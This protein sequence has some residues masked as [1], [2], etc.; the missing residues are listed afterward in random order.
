MQFRHS[1]KHSWDTSRVFYMNTEKVTGLDSRRAKHSYLLVRW[2]RATVFLVPW[3]IR[4]SVSSLHQWRLPSYWEPNVSWCSICI[5][6]GLQT[7]PVPLLLLIVFQSLNRVKLARLSSFHLALW[8][9]KAAVKLSKIMSI[10]C[11]C[12][13]EK[14]RILDLFIDKIKN[15]KEAVGGL[16]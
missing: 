1:K 11:C 12:H 16:E 2:R 13:L 15:L 7:A 5:V 8:T 6:E 4:L 14:A 10:L 3:E 9:L